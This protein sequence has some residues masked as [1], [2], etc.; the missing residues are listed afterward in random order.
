MRDIITL[1]SKIRY[2][3]YRLF[4]IYF[5]VGI[6]SFQ[7]TQNHIEDSTN[8]IIFHSPFLQKNNCIVVKKNGGDLFTTCL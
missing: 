4:I 3:P 6:Y 5:L 8:K 7:Y 1:S 2:H